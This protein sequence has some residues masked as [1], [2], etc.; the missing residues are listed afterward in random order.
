MIEK[1]IF[2]NVKTLLEGMVN[3]TDP[4]A[5]NLNWQ[6]FESM[7]ELLEPVGIAPNQKRAE[8]QTPALF[9]AFGE[10]ADQYIGT[11]LGGNDIGFDDVPSLGTIREM[12]PLIL[13]VLILDDGNGE[14]I[15]TQIA[16]AREDIRTVIAD[17]L[18]TSDNTNEKVDGVYRVYVGPYDLS[19]D[20]LYTNT[21]EFIIP[22]IVWWRHDYRD[23][24]QVV[25]ATSG[26]PFLEGLSVTRS[27]D[28]TEV[29]F[30]F[31]LPDGVTIAIK[32]NG[33]TVPNPTITLLNAETRLSS[34]TDDSWSIDD[35][36]QFEVT[37]SNGVTSE[38]PVLYYPYYP[39]M[40]PESLYDLGDSPE[41][42]IERK[43]RQMIQK[44]IDEESERFDDIIATASGPLSPNYLKPD[45]LPII[46][47]T[48][49][50]SALNVGSR[51]ILNGMSIS[52]PNIGWRTANARDQV[53]QL[54]AMVHAPADRKQTDPYEQIRIIDKTLSD[55]RSF[56]I[57]NEQWEGVSSVYQSIIGP[58]IPPR[59]AENVQGDLLFVGRF[60]FM[61]RY[62][63]S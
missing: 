51:T 37:D 52:N 53:L 57:A 4:D 8:E 34:W 12:T 17:K 49:D 58:I 11:G 5:Y 15:S 38:T 1:D 22:I 7:D 23:P 29:V 26:S 40:L 3:D 60:N 54:M 61:V 21:A 36:Y 13:R 63:E 42:N 6:L 2:D 56:V 14:F 24:S 32:K 59:R 30:S 50:Q 10:R 39:A 25:S 20:P 18:R 19:A 28:D 31:I 44:E 47:V 41:Q 27:F 16:K 55:L 35:T 9:M 62:R 33:S 45:N 48:F 43:I 46:C